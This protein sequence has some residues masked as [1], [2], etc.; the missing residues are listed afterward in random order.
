MLSMSLASRQ[1]SRTFC[2]SLL[3]SITIRSSH[4]TPLYNFVRQNEQASKLVKFLR[5]D[6]SEEPYSGFSVPKSASLAASLSPLIGM[7]PINS[8]MSKE[9]VGGINIAINAILR[10]LVNLETFINTFPELLSLQLGESVFGKRLKFSP[11]LLSVKRIEINSVFRYD[12]GILARNAV[13]ILAFCPNLRQ[14]IF[15]LLITIEDSKF[16]A[17][18]EE[19]FQGLSNVQDLAIR[20][21]YLFDKTNRRTWWGLPSETKQSWKKGSRK[22]D[23]I[24]HFLQVTNKLQS[25][26]MWSSRSVD[27]KEDETAIHEDCLDGLHNSF[28]TETFKAIRTT[29]K[30]S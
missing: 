22:S 17:E 28:E 14:A 1:A 9:Q 16:L 25:F 23:S 18:Y 5:I 12:E 24:F 27:R 19:T 13:W 26:E 6:N 20:I 3:Q 21:N 2:N 7:I 15:A 8:R 29:S 10:H 11:M 30:V 4:L